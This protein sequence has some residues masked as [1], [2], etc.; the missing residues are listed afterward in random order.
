MSRLAVHPDLAAHQ[1]HEPPADREPE[2][3]AAEL[4]RG[5]AIGLAERLE[6][7]RAGLGRDADAAVAH[8]D[9]E[10]DGVGSLVRHLDRGHH[11]AP[12]REL[13]GVSEQ[14]DEHLTEPAGIAAES[15][16]DLRVD[17]RRELETLGMGALGEQLRRLFHRG[18][19]GEVDVL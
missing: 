9:L 11:L 7:P 18:R 13:D 5:R 14:V 3:G 10:L 1:L 19:H 8:R 12:L 15:G 16:W 4:P 17:S 6:E 2:P